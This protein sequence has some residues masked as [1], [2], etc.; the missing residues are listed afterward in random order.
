MS[1]FNL[2]PMMASDLIDELETLIDQ[3]GDVMVIVA[4]N[5]IKV[6]EVQAYDINGDT[7]GTVVEFSLHGWK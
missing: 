7:K 2:P 6:R 4:S 1:D 3:H 5:D